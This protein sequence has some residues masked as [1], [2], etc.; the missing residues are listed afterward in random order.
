[1]N[2][3]PMANSPPSREVATSTTSDRFVLEDVPE[4][5]GLPD[6]EWVAE[7]DRAR[8]EQLLNSSAK[9]A[10]DA[11]RDKVETTRE[12]NLHYDHPILMLQH[13]VARGL[14]LHGQIADLARRASA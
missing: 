3:R 8:L 2:V 5:Q 4:F 13:M 9:A 6:E 1:M 7:P 10:A 14:H 11:V 12:M